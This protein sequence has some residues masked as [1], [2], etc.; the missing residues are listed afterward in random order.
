MSEKNPFEFREQRSKLLLRLLDSAKNIDALRGKS[1][2]SVMRDRT[3]KSELIES[4]TDDDYF[5]LLDGINGILRGKPKKDWRMDGAD[6]VIGAPLVPVEHVP[7]RQEDKVELLQGTLQVAKQ[8][9]H[10]GRVLE[11]VALLVAFAIND[12]HPYLDGN[13]RTG[14]F[15]FLMLAKDFEQAKDSLIDA[16]GEEG[17][18]SV[19]VATAYLHRRCKDI[20]I[21][22]RGLSD[23]SVNPDGIVGIF[24]EIPT[25][26]FKF[27]RG[28]DDETRRSIISAFRND[29]DDFKYAVIDH[30]LSRGEGGRYQK[31]FPERT[32]LLFDRMCEELEP[33]E[34]TEI[35]RRYWRMKKEVVEIALDAIANPDEP[36]YRLDPKVG[37]GS[38][39]QNFKKRCKT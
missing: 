18:E 1:L 6:V 9:V 10:D 31:K 28:V 26:E 25:N 5:G 19:D 16:L 8:M 23:E 30:V 12:I 37:G 27:K 21:K 29:T 36:E 39:F 38:I 4:L 22:R 34:L 3:T 14:R 24:N 15:V 35:L 33:D 11:D 20:W 7:P 13:G 2:E 32:V 17:R